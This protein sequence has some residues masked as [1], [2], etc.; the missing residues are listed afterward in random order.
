MKRRLTAWLL[1]LA[2][3]S[4][5]S[6][7]DELGALPPSNPSAQPALDRAWQIFLELAAGR[8]LQRSPTDSLAEQRLS[9]DIRYDRS[10]SSDWRAVFA[11]RVD[12][13]QPVQRAGTSSAINT[14]KEAYL[15]WQSSRY[16]V[17]LGRVDA[18]QGVSFGYNPTDYFRGDSV[19]SV[20]SADP[21]SLKKNRQGS[22]MLRGQT[23][24]DT[25]SVTSLYSPRLDQHANDHAFDP[26]WGAT[27]NRDR[28][29]IA[30]SQ[31]L[32]DDLTPQLLLYKQDGTPAQFG[33][34]ATTLINPSTTA[35]FEWSGGRSAS[36]LSQ[37]LGTNEKEPFQ[38]SYTVGIARTTSNRISCSLEFSYNSAALGTTQWDDLRLASPLSYEQFNAWSQMAQDPPTRK[39]VLVY[40]TW[41]DAGVSQLDLSAMLRSSLVDH[42]IESWLE[43]RYHLSQTDISLQW[44]QNSGQPVSQFGALPQKR[45]GELAVRHYF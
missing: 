35:Y 40:L 19:R 32:S 17:D 27:N 25:G 18:R 20:V 2:L 16:Q 29:L 44:Q 43:V 41:R 23:F 37:A 14:L 45:V 39:S 38:N 5:Q 42:S 6:Q 28:L 24:W 13:D 1:L 30:A 9:L 7:E 10:F 8:I 34:N 26:D 36:L 15:N 11:D 21:V 33:L 12:I 31:R 4:A 22:V 3:T